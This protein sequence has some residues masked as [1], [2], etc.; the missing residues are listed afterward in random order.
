MN[1][2]AGEFSGNRTEDWNL[3]EALKR[4][5]RRIEAEPTSF[6]RFHVRKWLAYPDGRH[7]TAT[8]VKSR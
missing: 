7:I 2:N 8:F 3:P 5:L 1:D 4:Y 6:N